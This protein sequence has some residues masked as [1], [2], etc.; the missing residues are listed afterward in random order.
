LKNNVLAYR[1]TFQPGK[2]H[3][4]L[5]GLWGIAWILAVIVIA[6]KIILRNENSKK[7][8]LKNN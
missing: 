2:R 6:K 1:E 7:D 4:F 5:F 3:Y 8:I